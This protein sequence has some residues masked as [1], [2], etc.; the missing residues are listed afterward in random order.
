MIYFLRAEGFCAK[1]EGSVETLK[2]I[3]DHNF[4]AKRQYFLKNL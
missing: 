1:D 3:S 4:V 2:A